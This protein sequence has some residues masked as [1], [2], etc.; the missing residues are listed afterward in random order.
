M[1]VQL[2]NCLS[3]FIIDPTRPHACEAFKNS[4]R[5]QVIEPTVDFFITMFSER[6]VYSLTLDKYL[7]EPD[8]PEETAAGTRFYRDLG[9]LDCLVVKAKR[10]IPLDKA[11]K[12][13]VSMEE[14]RNGLSKLCTLTPAL[15][16]QQIS[17]KDGMCE[18]KI[19]TKQKVLVLWEPD[20]SGDEDR[21]FF[22][23]LAPYAGLDLWE[24]P[25]CTRM[26]V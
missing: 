10:Q 25:R 23:E 5:E 21:T 20:F 11:I 8:D 2:S 15:K 24:W 6:N 19:L 1:A 9:D 18:T 14:R 7:P 17:D 12:P 16:M 4:L 13:E 22:Q 26:T 3:I